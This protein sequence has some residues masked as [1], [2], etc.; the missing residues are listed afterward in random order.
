[1][2]ISSANTRGYAPRSLRPWLAT[3]SNFAALRRWTSLPWLHHLPQA[4]L[5]LAGDSDPIV[6]RFNAELLA[7]RIPHS[8]LEIIERGGHLFMFTHAEQIAQTV[9]EFLDAD[10]DEASLARA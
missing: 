9:R 3:H 8:R 1:M 5:V 7:K 4:T 2:G 10:E 6:P